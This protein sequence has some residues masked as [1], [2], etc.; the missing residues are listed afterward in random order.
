MKVLF[1]IKPEL[2][3]IEVGVAAAQHDDTVQRLLLYLHNFDEELLSLP[4]SKRIIGANEEGLYP[5]KVSDI[6]HFFTNGRNCYARTCNT[7]THEVGIYRIKERIGEL[8]H[9]LDEH[10]FVKVNQSEIVQI[11][12][13]ERFV[14]AG[15]TSIELV[16]IDGTRCFVSRRMIAHFKRVLGI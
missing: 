15:A 7:A 2:S 14:P 16:L 1:T 9:M 5:L 10:E 11:S 3:E 12:Y 8:E 4:A 6:A 13:I